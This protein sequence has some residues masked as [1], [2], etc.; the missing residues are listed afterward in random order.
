M[1]MMNKYL[2]AFAIACLSSI[3]LAETAVIVH[4]D[5]GISSL[6]DQD[7]SRIFL[8]KSKS[9]PNGNKVAP[10][11]QKDGAARDTFLKEVCKKSASQYKAYWSKLVFTGKGTPP[12]E[13]S[14]DAEVKSAVAS[15]PEAIGYID[16]SAVDAS[17]RVV[18][19]LP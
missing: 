8:G 11:N 18:Y 19:K 2:A 9:Y 14:G 17:V 6:N 12:K 13:L 10:I 5:S 1:K 7:I 4:P 15:N 16:A 3:S